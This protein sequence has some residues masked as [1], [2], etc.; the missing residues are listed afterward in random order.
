MGR[1]RLLSTIYRA[2]GPRPIA[3]RVGPIMLGRSILA[4][5]SRRAQVRGF[6]ELMTRRRDVWRAVNGVIDRAGIADSE[7]A[8]ITA[9]TL[10]IVGDEDVATPRDKADALVRSIAGARLALIARAGHSSTVEE[11]AEVSRVIAEF[12]ER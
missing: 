10:V 8:Q 7:L 3:S 9:P 2:V 5:P 4:D 12:L 11:P 6:I 1:Y